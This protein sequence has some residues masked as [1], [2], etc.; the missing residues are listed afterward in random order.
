MRYWVT[1]VIVLVLVAPFDFGQ[2][3]ANPTTSNPPSST[4]PSGEANFTPEQLQKYYLVYTNPD[5]RYLRTLFDE[6]L[7]GKTGKE[8]EF[9]LLKGWGSDYYRSK[10]VV[11]SRDGNTFGGTLIT[12]IFQDRPDK[13][14]VAWVY[15]EGSA[16]KLTLR[17]FDPTK[18]TEQDVKQVGIR[19]RK[20]L[21]DKKHAM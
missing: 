12:I 7:H 14:F 15:P 18:Y 6:Y 4:I 20:V 11:L 8:D 17:T 16:Q 5:V 10:F 9:S 19:Y 21:E 13:I 2:Q 3:A 1:T